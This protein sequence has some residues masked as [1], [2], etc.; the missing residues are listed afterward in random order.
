[1]T[2]AEKEEGLEVFK[3]EVERFSP[4]LNIV[5]YLMCTLCALEVDL[6]DSNKK[7]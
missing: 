5:A 6:C 4:L 2:S 1:M 3:E 7:Q